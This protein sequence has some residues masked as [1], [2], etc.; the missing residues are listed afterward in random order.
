MHY[1]IYADSVFFLN[2][3]MNLY[4]L[5]LVD[6][7]T[8]RDAS[9]GRLIGG[10]AVGA[11]CFLLPFWGSGPAI[12]KLALAMLAGIVGMLC[13]TFRVKGLRTFLKL[14]ERLAIYSFG[15]GGAML[16]LVRTFSGIR[17]VMLSVP[18]ILGMGLLFFLLFRRF[19]E[20]TCKGEILCRAV[21]TRGDGQ[22]GVMALVDS[23]NSLTEPISGEPVCVVGKEIYDSLWKDGASGFRAIPYHSIGRKRGILPGYVLPGLW[24]EVDGMGYDFT[25]VYVAV[26]EER[27]SGTDSADA[28]SVDMIINPR[29]FEK[30]KKGRPKKRQN[31]RHE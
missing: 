21:L 18:G 12:W 23:G 13:I 10:A 15:M 17:S 19:R 7:N 27:I 9:L 6:R 4:L 31:E 28:E 16:F 2:F 29:L 22:I 24:L 1:E 14:L 5:L 20:G 26:S 8:L 25:D 3:I 11:A 30:G